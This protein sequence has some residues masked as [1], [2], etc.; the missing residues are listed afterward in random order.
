[1]R[2]TDEY[3]EFWGAVFQACRLHS[4]GL[5]LDVFLEDPKGHLARL[6]LSD[7][8]EIMAGGFLPLRPDQAR[9]RLG[10]VDESAGEAA[11]ALAECDAAARFVPAFLRASA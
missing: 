3:I 9:V 2:W 7:A 1:M 8:L 10:L 5:E 4:A 6:G 11:P